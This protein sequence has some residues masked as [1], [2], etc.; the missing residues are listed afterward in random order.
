MK[1]ATKGK[2]AVKRAA[3][4]GGVGMPPDQYAIVMAARER[5]ASEMGYEMSR[6]QAIAL[7]C[8][9]YLETCYGKR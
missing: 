9:R 5:L 4:W 6:G 7:I 3:K 8:L 2:N 1:K